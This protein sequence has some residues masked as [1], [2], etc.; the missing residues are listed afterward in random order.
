MSS[1][2]FFVT[3]MGIS[4]ACISARGDETG[5]DV[6]PVSSRTALANFK[7]KTGLEL[8]HDEHHR[9]LVTGV[10]SD[11]DSARRG[12]KVGD[13]IIR[14]N[15]AE[16]K[17][18]ESLQAYLD[19][20]HGNDRAFL[21]TFSRQ[22]RVFT[23][24]LGRHVALV[25]MFIFGDAADRP[26]VQHVAS[27]SAAEAAG[28]KKGDLIAGVE[29]HVCQNMHR[30]IE[31]VTKELQSLAEGNEF[32]LRLLRDGRTQERRI[33]RRGEI[34]VP[35]VTQTNVTT[36]RSEPTRP[37]LKAKTQ[38]SAVSVASVV[39]VLRA[40]GQ[41]VGV[42]MC[43]ALQAIQ[44]LPN[45]RKS[46]AS[47]QQALLEAQLVGLATGQ[48]SLV[49]FRYG[50]E[51]DETGRSAGEVVTKLADIVVDARGTA[52]VK[53]TQLDLAPEGIL[54]RTIGIV[55]PTNDA[56]G[57]QLLASGVAGLTNPNW[58]PAV[59]VPNAASP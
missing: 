2:R 45:E 42:V 15:D 53:G 28:V 30:F 43:G 9:V 26:L 11:T 51:R 10:R 5:V 21:V 58:V 57:I 12:V 7:A 8:G 23:A 18:A 24:P 52:I 39:A 36:I 20:H 48:Y 25:G 27:G 49:M 46:S 34:S 47:R 59:A 56:A 1:L 13:I 33:V 4:V 38:T 35:Q 41:T 37:T 32:S 6:K 3:A 50:D 19:D 16:I 31:L 22:S 55:R 44:N 40:K 29:G 14:V 54:G 17:N